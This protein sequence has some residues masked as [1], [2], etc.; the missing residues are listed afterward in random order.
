VKKI[1]VNSFHKRTSPESRYSFC[2][3]EKTFQASNVVLACSHPDSSLPHPQFFTHYPFNLRGILDSQ[4]NNT[5]PYRCQQEID[6]N[7]AV[8]AI[9]V[10]KQQTTINLEV[11]HA[12]NNGTLVLEECF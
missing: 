11:L 9:F 12:T 4:C 7:S 3:S 6:N 2:P 8:T 5:H 1:F 10:T